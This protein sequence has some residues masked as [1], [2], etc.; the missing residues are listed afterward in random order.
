MDVVTGGGDAL[1]T[2]INNFATKPQSSS[3]STLFYKK[4]K[5]LSLAPLKN[6]AFK[7]YEIISIE[8]E[9]QF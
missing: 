7:V 9:I 1:L 2:P 3:E 4:Y 5:N 8:I 6:I